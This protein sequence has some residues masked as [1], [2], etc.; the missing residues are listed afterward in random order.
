M[1]QTNK[2]TKK[3]ADKDSDRKSLSFN[4]VQEIIDKQIER[5][6]TEKQYTEPI[7]ITKRRCIDRFLNWLFR[8]K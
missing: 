2:P 7:V 1:K 6:K 4:Q 8:K 3:I 5:I